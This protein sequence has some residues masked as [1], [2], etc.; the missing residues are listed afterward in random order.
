M[1]R[2]MVFILIIALL[3][4]T[5]CGC[6]APE[7]TPLEQGK[8]YEVV[9]KDDYKVT[10]EVISQ[11]EEYFEVAV[12]KEKNDGYFYIDSNDSDNP[13]PILC[14]LAFVE[15]TNQSQVFKYVLVNDT[16]EIEGD[17]LGGG[18]HYGCPWTFFISSFDESVNL[19]FYFYHKQ[20]EDYTVKMFTRKVLDYSIIKVGAEK[21][22]DGGYNHSASI[23]N[24]IAFQVE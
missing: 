18:I 14:D 24:A 9:I 17:F 4:S 5:L 3:I 6:E 7:K 16:T 2:T 23:I 11:T 13:D 10:I 1:K 21:N 12:T 19:K 8:S 22:E 20:T 15:E